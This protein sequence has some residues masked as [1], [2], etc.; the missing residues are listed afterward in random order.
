[1]NTCLDHF[2]TKSREIL[3]DEAVTHPFFGQLARA[4]IPKVSNSFGYWDDLYAHYQ[5]AMHTSRVLAYYMPHLDSP[6]LRRVKLEIL[7]E[8][9][10]LPEGDMHHLQ[11]FRTW[12][13]MLGRAPLVDERLF[14]STSQLKGAMPSLA[15][16]IESCERN[17]TS[18]LGAWYAVE[19]L[20]HHWI[21][22]L[23]SALEPHFP[24]ASETD[25]FVMNFHNEIEVHHAEVSR[26]TV[27]KVL[28]E[29][30]ELTHQT[31]VGISE[32]TSALRELWSSLSLRLALYQTTP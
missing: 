28:T 3:K 10:G 32:T 26:T 2:S 20:A 7:A 12:S 8:D 30:P 25:Y 22:D 11:L 5:G 16:F 19:N 6:D 15:A 9:D 24:G 17:Y 23:M 27:M 29:R 14:G 18:N 21:G 31:L 4:K 13:R 1:M